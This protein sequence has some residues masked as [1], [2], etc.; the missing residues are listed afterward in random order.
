MRAEGQAPLWDRSDRQRCECVGERITA[1]YHLIC[2]DS[3][4]LA[5]FDLPEMDFCITSPPYMPHWHKWNPLYNGDP[6]YDGYDVYLKRMQEIYG[7]IC[8]RMKTNAYLVV[9]ADNL[10]NEQ[11]SPLVWDLGRTLSAVMT[12][13]GEIMVNWSGAVKGGSP[14]TQ[15]LV[16]RNASG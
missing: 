11:F 1:K 12:L 2:G 7:R 5:A 8:R 14:F 9:Q 10:T 16:F 4:E 3:A 13:E 6:D 15:C